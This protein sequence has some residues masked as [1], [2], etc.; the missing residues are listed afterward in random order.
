MN[1]EFVIGRPLDVFARIESTYRAQATTFLSNQ[2]EPSFQINPGTSMLHTEVE[3]DCLHDLMVESMGDDISKSLLVRNQKVFEMGD[4]ESDQSLTW[5]KWDA[6]CLGRSRVKCHEQL[7][8]SRYWQSSKYSLISC[9][10]EP[11]V[12]FPPN[13]DKRLQI[14]KQQIQKSNQNQK[15]Y[16][17]NW[18]KILKSGICRVYYYQNNNRCW[19]LMMYKTLSLGELSQ[20]ETLY[21]H[22]VA[23]L[24][25][26]PNKKNSGESLNNILP[27]RK[28]N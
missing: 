13:E 21:V 7:C 27:K 22:H 12:K 3:N 11:S 20:M 8:T 26:L 5:A 6:E 23:M 1:E 19:E 17:L 18:S 14:Y 4:T 15:R 24:F 10:A 2:H 25:M 16:H 28:S 9:N